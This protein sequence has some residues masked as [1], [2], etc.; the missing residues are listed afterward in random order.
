MSR[1]INVYYNVVLGASAGLLAWIL[2]S[3]IPG[4]EEN[5]VWIRVLVKGAVVGTLV[6]GAL[7]SVEGLLDRARNK[8][9]FGCIAGSGIG[10]VGGAAGLE[11]GEGIFRATG[12]GIAGRSLGWAFFGLL[13][14]ASD[15]LVSRS[16]KKSVYGAIGGFAGGFLGGLVLE[17]VT[18]QGDTSTSP[19]SV[20]LGLV[21][22]G[23]LVGSLITSVEEIFSGARIRV[24]SG[25]LE[26]REFNITK[27]VSTLGSH[28]RSDLLVT[29]DATIA[30]V[31]LEIRQERRGFSLVPLEAG[32]SVNKAV[33][34]NIYFLKNRDRFQVGNTTLLF[35]DR[36]RS[37]QRAR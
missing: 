24:L 28:D 25:V 20:G 14:G 22:L 26:G 5:N 34:S 1:K 27:K 29:G 21:L 17:S 10:L 12:G 7:G 32:V 30:P 19:W 13:V 16:P 8:A 9:I 37:D 18:I 11:I 35:M 33:V 36:R 15:G 2:L 3:I 6:G 31:Q 23:A 4:L